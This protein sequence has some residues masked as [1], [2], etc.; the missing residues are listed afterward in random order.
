MRASRNGQHTSGAESICQD[1]QQAQSLAAHYLQRAIAHPHG[2][3]DDV[4]L[5]ISAIATPPLR[6]PRLSV[7]EVHCAN[8]EQARAW[9]LDALGTIPA[10]APAVALLHSVRRMRGAVLLEAKNARRYEP[11]SQRGVRASTFGVAPA[12]DA[13]GVEYAAEVDPAKQYH[14]EALILASKVAACPHMLAELCISDDPDYTT[15]YVAMDGTYFRIHNIKP[16][17]SDS[18]GRMFIFDGGPSPE[19]RALEVVEFLE[20]QAVLVQ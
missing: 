3:P 7:Q 15:G 12:E 2:R 10:A 6:V 4:H 14:S 16:K 5:H 11:D 18:G 13:L 17:G 9:M 1:L 19:V 20:Q 8:P